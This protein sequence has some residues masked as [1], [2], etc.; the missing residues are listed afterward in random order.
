MSPKADPVIDEIRQVRRRISSRFGHDPY[1]VV[2]YY[3]QV[4]EQLAAEA[5]TKPIAQEAPAA[6]S[7]QRPSSRESLRNEG[8]SP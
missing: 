3:M 4:E 1:K 2:D 6:D 5:A 7:R 8:D